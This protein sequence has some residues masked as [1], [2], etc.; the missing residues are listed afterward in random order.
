MLCLPINQADPDQ[1]MRE[2]DRMVHICETR[3]VMLS[4]MYENGGNTTHRFLDGHPHLHVY[5]YESQLGNEAMSDYLSQ[6]FPAK[7]RYPD[8]PT[9]ID[10]ETAYE[11]FYD[12][13]MKTRLRAP[14]VSK[15]RDAD[16]DLDEVDRKACFLDLMA[17]SPKTRAFYV[18]A[19]FEATF[20]AWKNVK[21]S[22]SEDVYVGYSPVI[23]FDAE[24]FL[25]DFPNGH[26]IHVVRNPWSGYADTIKRPFP[27]TLDR[28]A[29]TWAMVQHRALV[30]AK[31]HP[32][33]FHIL[34]F[35]DLV[36]DPSAAMTSLSK[37]IGIPFDESLLAPSWNGIAL[38]NIRP[39]G[40]IATP[41]PDANIATMNELSP[42]QIKEI[43]S[44]TAIMLP[45]FGYDSFLSEFR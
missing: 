18:S 13:E 32:D 4:A 3:L 14:R 1:Y 33:Q 6:I 7:Y 44:L 28:Y 16:M 11:L 20:K 12:E 19:F 17:N 40:T 43:E 2:I 34:R 42:D 38:S 31:K 26:M 37:N 15:F 5:P 24:P 10:D 29:W 41:T 23:A 25:S 30:Y 35:E 21:R 36:A 8:F 27:R 39:W 9:A 45:H 22:G